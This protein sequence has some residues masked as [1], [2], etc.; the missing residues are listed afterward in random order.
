MRFMAYA[1]LLGS[2]G[3]LGLGCG[4]EDAPEQE[5]LAAAVAPGWDEGSTLVE[6]VAEEAGGITRYPVILT[7]RADHQWSS[8]LRLICRSNCERALLAFGYRSKQFVR[9]YSSED[10][11]RAG[12]RLDAAVPIVDLAIDGPD[13]QPVLAAYRV[14]DASEA[15]DP[16]YL[17]RLRAAPDQLY[18]PLCEDFLRSTR[19]S[20]ETV[21]ISKALLGQWGV[22]LD[23]KESAPPF[24][25]IGCSALDGKLLPAPGPLVTGAPS[26]APSAPPCG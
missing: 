10:A 11:L 15:G 5:V 25:R 20:L 22:R 2:V 13:E 8:A 12:E 24:P 4:V 23:A 18:A 1:A 19:G 16:R 3:V 21:P 7:P 9:E 17:V 6:L 14:I 26:W